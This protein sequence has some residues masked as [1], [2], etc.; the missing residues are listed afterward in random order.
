MRPTLLASFTCS[1]SE[2]RLTGRHIVGTGTGGGA[3]WSADD[4]SRLLSFPRK[5]DMS[6]V[7]DPLRQFPMV[8]WREGSVVYSHHKG[9]TNTTDGNLHH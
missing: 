7:V 8:I 5:R 9:I 3:T 1:I 2:R 4:D 6:S